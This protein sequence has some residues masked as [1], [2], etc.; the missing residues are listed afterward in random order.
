M[1]KL[2]TAL[3]ILGVM[4]LVFV[5]FV[6]GVVMWASSNVSARS[7]KKFDFPALNIAEKV[8][9]ADIEL[10]RKIVRIRNGCTDCHGADLAGKTF[11]ND[12]AMGMFS[13]ANITPYALASKS[14][15][16]VAR[17]IYYGV[18]TNG[19][20]LIFMPSQE[21]HNLALDDIAAAVAYLRTIPA[22]TKPNTEIQIGT[23]AKLLGASGKMPLLI[24]AELISANAP[25]KVKP[26]ERNTPEFGKYLV[27]SGCVGCHGRDLKG[28]PI[29]GGDPS[30]P[31]AANL[32]AASHGTW[33]EA[34][35]ISTIRTG[36][37][38]AGRPLMNPM[39][40]VAENA[41]QA[42]DDELKAIWSYLTT[43]KN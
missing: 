11:I 33:K 36:K 4:L 41:K 18:R 28:G 10:G 25:P 38:P 2:K 22:V 14:D 40:G 3:K 29:P 20:P 21:F 7:Q 1:K 24:S 23:V 9:T 15:E 39:R 34:D 17:A 5:L 6:G 35:F 37:R 19:T 8:K 27:E 31:P 32:V 16:E 43:L 26:P 42:S 12:P 30:W 13:G